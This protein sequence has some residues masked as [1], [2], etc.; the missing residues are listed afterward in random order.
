MLGGKTGYTKKSGR[1][2]VSACEKN[3]T[4]LIAVTLNAPDDWNDHIKMYD[5]GYS[6]LSRIQI[7]EHL[8]DKIK[9]FS[10]EKAYIGI[11]LS[12]KDFSSNHGDKYSYRV[13]IPDWV[14]APIRK[15]DVIG[16][17][18]VLIGN[19][20]IKKIDV[21]AGENVDTGKTYKEKPEYSF[22]YKL[23]QLIT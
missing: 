20:I 2:L 10:G 1:C 8:T 19:T 12:D 17:I 13:V 6:A 3:G 9:V 4:T 21:I 22:L 11:T 5:Y 16:F 18:E 7:N 15:N 14:Y 23:R